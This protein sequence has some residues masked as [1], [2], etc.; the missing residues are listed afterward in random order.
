MP[1]LNLSTNASLDGVDTSA[2]LSVA[3]K[4]VARLI[5][6]P[7]A[8]VM[9]VL[10]GSVPISFGGNEQPAAYGELVSIG[11]LNPD[12]NKKLS[13][14]IAEILETKLSVPKSR[15]FLKFYDTKGSNFGWNGS[16][17]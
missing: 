17:F 15:F 9:V 6:K 7:E 14:A 12:T 4:T 11:G 16:T 8:Y 1:C 2:I 10:K 5:G 3:S 13:A